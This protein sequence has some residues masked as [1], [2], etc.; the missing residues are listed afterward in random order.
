MAMS[1]EDLHTLPCFVPIPQLNCHII[2]GGKNERLGGVND[3]RANVV[4][5]C[6]EGGDLLGG[7]VI[8]D[9]KLEVI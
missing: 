3:N 1:L 5:M 9:S 6:F 7:V 8:V 2:R 4:G